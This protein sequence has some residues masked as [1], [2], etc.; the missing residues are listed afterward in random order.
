MSAKDAANWEKYYPDDLNKNNQVKTGQD[1]FTIPAADL[2]IGQQ[3]SFN[4]QWVYPNGKV[5]PWSDGLTLTTATYTT[6]LTKPTITVTPASLGYT[7]SYTKQTDKNFD[8]AIIEEA[9]ST[10]NTAPTSGYQEV[11]V[12][13]SNPITITVGDVL[14]RWVRLKLTDKIAG[15]TA[16][17]DPVA[18]TP[19]D[20]VAAALDITPP[21]AASGITASWSG[22]NIL[23][24]ATVSADA[25]KFI[26]RL[27]N[28]AD[29][30]FFTKFPSTSGTSQSIL[31]TQQEL[32]VTFGEYFTSF[33]GLFVSADSLD[34]RDSGVSFI[35]PEKTNVLLGVVP[36]FTLTGITNG[37]TAT[38]TLPA[39]A[40]Y[41]KVYES[42]TSWGAGNPTE[43]DLVFSGASP[44]IIKK[45]VY[46]LRYVKIRYL[47]DDGFTSSW[48]AEQSVTPIDAI[49]ADVNAPN[50]PSTISATAGTDSTGTVGFNGVVNISWSAVSDSTLRG[51]RIRFR[52][53][54][55][56]A[57]FENYSHVDSPGTGTSYRLS[58]LA[59]GTTYEVGI[60]SYDEF[61]NT[62][63]AYTALSPNIAVSGNP[64]IGTN[65]STTG[66]FEAGVA[67]T[68]TGTFKF[69]YGVDTGKRGLVLNSS[70]YWY[71]DSA[72]SALFKIGGSTSN[73]V[74]WNGT[75]LSIDGDLGVAG[76][77]TIGGNIAM[78]ASGASIYQGT[79]NGS[80][81]LTSDGFLLNSSG[82]VIKKNAI[83]LRLD[84]S[85]GGIYAEYGQI[86][87]WTIDSSKFERGTT[88]TYTGI[89]SSGTYAI[90]AGS[91]V[92]AGNSSA[93]FS[94]TP[95]GAVTASDITI[96]G[97]SLTVGASSIAAST[98]KLIS[99]DAE[100]T[101]KITASTGKIG[102]INIDSGGLYISDAVVPSPLSGNRIVFSGGGIASYA[103]GS[104]TPKFQLASDGTA[105]VGGWTINETSLSSAGI[106][107]NAGSQHISFTN[108]FLIDND[109]F[110]Y[111]IAGG[112]QASS[113][114]YG[115]DTN[116]DGFVEDSFVSLAP[117]TASAS[118]ISIKPSSSYN[119]TTSPALF[120][121]TSGY[122][123]LQ[124]G[125]SYISL[126]NTGVVINTNTVGGIALKGF[127]TAYHRMYNPLK[128]AGAVLQ[129]FSDGRVTA[130]RAFYKSGASET[131]ITNINHS[132]WPSV[133]LIGDVIFSTAD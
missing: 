63:Y 114:Y 61:N 74:S 103:S 11:G 119:A 80:G 95:A 94:V 44:A 75:K 97:G 43:S 62:S 76:G 106:T 84:T 57:P 101:G 2:K 66:Y 132:T 37:Y 40:S 113:T 93:K 111:N 24:T 8:N 122:S 100:I 83:Q 47:T 7:V 99:T 112:V 50:A 133:G 128:E 4:F 53:Y 129:I 48:S 67:G 51:Y 123:T 60:A 33:T 86:A 89:S 41:A 110:T 78:G 17:S 56:S 39:G 96:T 77:T 36:T 90:W 88:G 59:L 91:P 55:A 116:T 35:V 54:K 79:L 87:G 109:N 118:S 105:K 12:T 21:T 27:T 34:N 32:Y 16:Y 65:V 72:Q 70:N 117:G 42:G 52:P 5:S 31:I 14:K 108:G 124:A 30:G 15:N 120:M 73:Y 69:G 130:G 104:S 10:S 81:N 23:I 68:D 121:S 25:K 64:F 13:S 3:Y 115:S 127:A 98:G 29:E 92:S 102:N 28:G 45:T 58:G 19:V 20:P 131:S 82:L 26:I 22:N 18:V 49:A 1:Y 38:W 125:G 107:L 9:V 85:D 6:K 126:S 46:T 71:I